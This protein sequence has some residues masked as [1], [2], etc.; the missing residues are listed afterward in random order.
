MDV[1]KDAEFVRSFGFGLAHI[2][3][4]LPDNMRS[5][6]ME[7]KGRNEDFMAG[8]GTGLGHHLPSIGTRIVEEAILSI[9]SESFQIGLARGFAASFKYLSMPEVPGIL[10]YTKCYV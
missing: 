3:S 2:F 10:E 4:I 7:T 1:Q 5:K 6:I 8:L 9:R